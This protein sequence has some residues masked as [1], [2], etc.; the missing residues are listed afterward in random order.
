MLCPSLDYLFNMRDNSQT[1]HTPFKRLDVSQGSITYAGTKTWNQI[2]LDIRSSPSLNSF[3][4]KYK[5]H[6]LSTL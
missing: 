6:L 2:P 4:I 3:K 1:F 5:E